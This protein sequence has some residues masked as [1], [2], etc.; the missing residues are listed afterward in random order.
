MVNEF[1]QLGSRGI[2][3]PPFMLSEESLTV[4]WELMLSLRWPFRLMW[5]IKG[6]LLIEKK[7]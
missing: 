1:I 3:V 7:Y 4:Y 5:R 2:F 6:C